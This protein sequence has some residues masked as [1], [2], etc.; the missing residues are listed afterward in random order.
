MN[1]ITARGRVLKTE[2][3]IC[4]D[5]YHRHGSPIQNMLALDVNGHY[6]EITQDGARYNARID[7]GP[8]CFNLTDIQLD[9]FIRDNT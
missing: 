5:P 3:I 4:H 8:A 7:G 6:V 9:Q 1:A 2:Q